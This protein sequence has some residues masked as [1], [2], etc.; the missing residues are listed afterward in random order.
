[1]QNL[2]DFK[3]IIILTDNADSGRVW[4]EQTGAALGSTPLLMVISAQAEP[5]LLPYYDSGQVQGL[6]TGL[7]GGEAYAQTVASPGGKTSLVQR[8]WNSFSAGTLVA[9]LLIVV[10]GAWNTFSGWRARSKKSG[11]EA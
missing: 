2:S 7:A 4:V 10:G 8:Y 9:I 1:V 6:V 5:M 3:A 11:E